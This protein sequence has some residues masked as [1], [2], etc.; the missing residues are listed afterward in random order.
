MNR[1]MTMAMT[2]RDRHKGQFGE[3]VLS[4]K[5]L[6]AIKTLGSTVKPLSL[7]YTSALHPEGPR[8]EHQRYN[9]LNGAFYVAACELHPHN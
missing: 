5:K 8:F 1:S 6:A 3:G 4:F 9:I 2:W 7:L